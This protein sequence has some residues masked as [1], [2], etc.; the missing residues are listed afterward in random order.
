MRSS[1]ASA[2]PCCP[3]IA[4]SRN[5]DSCACCR[6]RTCR[7]WTAFW[8]TPRSSR[9]S[10]GFRPFAI[11]LSARRS[12]G[13]TEAREDGRLG[14]SA[15]EQPVLPGL[16]SLLVY[17]L[18]IDVIL[19]VASAALPDRVDHVRQTRVEIDRRLALQQLPRVVRRARRVFNFLPSPLHEDGV[20]I[21]L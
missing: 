2:S 14:R 20:E 6:K 4:C 17:D 9:T 1:T 12:G 5:R 3:T 8:C 13:A 10:P 7:R 15:S 18:E 21:E 19:E 16:R 11:F